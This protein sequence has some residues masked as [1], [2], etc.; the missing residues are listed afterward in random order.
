M[1]TGEG[2]RGNK[3]AEERKK[4]NSPDLPS[5]LPVS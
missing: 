4:G 3:G 5:C 2:E 1:G